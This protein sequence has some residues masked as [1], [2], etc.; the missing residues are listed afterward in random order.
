[1]PKDDPQAELAR[2]VRELRARHKLS[3]EELGRRAGLHPTNISLIESGNVNP[4][5]GSVWRLAQAL[6]VTLAE[7]AAMTEEKH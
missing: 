3:Q 4:S 1:M 7:L 2:V 6:H 5:W